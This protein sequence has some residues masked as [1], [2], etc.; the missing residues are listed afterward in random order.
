[1]FSNGF[2]NLASTYALKIKS[3]ITD[4]AASLEEERI[5]YLQ[6]K[7]EQD[8]GDFSERAES[9][10]S[11]ERGSSSNIREAIAKVLPIQLS[12][13][14]TNFDAINLD[15]ALGDEI[16]YERNQEQ[17]TSSRGKL[18]WEGY[19]NSDSL[20]AKILN[21]SEDT[22]NFLNEVPETEDFTF[23]LSDSYPTALL[24]LDADS[25]LMDMRFQ[26]VPKK[27]KDERFWHAY[28]FRIHQLCKQHAI[29]PSEPLPSPIQR[30]LDGALDSPNQHSASMDGDYASAANTET[31]FI[32]PEPAPSPAPPPLSAAQEVAVPPHTPELNRPETPPLN[33]IEPLPHRSNTPSARED[34]RSDEEQLPTAQDLRMQLAPLPKSLPDSPMAAYDGEEFVSDMYEN[35]WEDAHDEDEDY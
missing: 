4:A 35:E 31:L 2:A 14:T 19:E 3:A 33:V 21:I 28:F 6:E 10:I 15:E 32:A 30:K 18:P 11:A 13:V 5:T 7:K 12:T 1:M 23:N 25:S 27:M 22:Y 29:N 9:S 26:L 34:L 20:R 24:L 16:E 8:G 17:S